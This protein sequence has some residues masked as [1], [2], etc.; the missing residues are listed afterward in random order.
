[1][2]AAAVRILVVGNSTART[3]S[4][5]EALA[6]SG[7]DSHSVKTV[8]E[9]G[10][11]L[12]TIRFHLTFAA[13]KLPD[14]TGYELAA[15]IAQ[16]SGNLFI[17]VPLSETCLWLPVVE[18]GKRSLGQRALNPLTLARE[19][20]VILRAGDTAVARPESERNG[21]GMSPHAVAGAEAPPARAIAQLTET[22]RFGRQVRERYEYREGAGLRRPM[23]ARGQLLRAAS[24][25]AEHSLPPER[26]GVERE[27]VAQGKR[28]RG[29]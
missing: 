28:W 6:R 9:A 29:F 8:R 17:Y 24:V 19:A 3:E 21:R 15:L 22:E 12:R 23:A 16:Q 2:S 26:K 1:M 11:V 4:T 5:L 18:N 14:G 27:V 13:E 10:A 7:W 25:A 20:E